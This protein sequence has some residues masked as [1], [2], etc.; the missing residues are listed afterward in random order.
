MT[1]YQTQAQHTIQA[2]YGADHILIYKKATI[3]VSPTKT[4]K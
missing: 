4:Q 1:E 3:E 2:H